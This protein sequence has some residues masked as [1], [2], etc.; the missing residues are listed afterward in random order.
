MRVP[1]NVQGRTDGCNR[2]QRGTYGYVAGTFRRVNDRVK[3]L[4][5]GRDTRSIVFLAEGCGLANRLRAMVG[6][7]ALARLHKLQFYLRWVMDP[8]CPCEFTDLFC[9]PIM[10]IG[11]QA[12]PSV[13]P[14]TIYKEAIWF[15]KIWERWG[16]DLDWEKYLRE[17]HGCLKELTPQLKLAEELAEFDRRHSLSDAI[18]IHIRNTDNIAAYADWTRNNAD[19]DPSK[20]S[21]LTAFIDVIRAHIGS[22]TVLLAT[23]DPELEKELKL[24]FPALLT[25]SKSYDLTQLRTTPMDAAV[26]EMW[27]LGRCCQIVGTY[28]SSFGKFSAVWGRIPYFQVTGDQIVRSEFV[29]RLISTGEY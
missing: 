14:C 23:D 9:S 6:Y 4:F 27:L 26:S 22:R 19:F 1:A 20:T 29:D 28:Y 8:T 10:V 12:L 11:H 25:F 18:G 2:E 24:K 15:D 21:R 3:D 13:S 7:Q 5:L 17:V 16:A